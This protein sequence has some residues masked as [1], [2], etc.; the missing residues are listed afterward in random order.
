VAGAAAGNMQLARFKEDAL[1][2]PPAAAIRSRSLI[3]YYLTAC[4]FFA[5]T[6]CITTKTIN[7]MDVENSVHLLK[8]SSVVDCR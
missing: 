1:T 7:V 6:A 5:K 3:L 2:S 4:V 8:S